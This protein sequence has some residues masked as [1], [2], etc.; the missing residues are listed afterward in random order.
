[1]RAAK[2]EKH[3]RAH[4]FRHSFATHVLEAGTDIRTLQELL[5]HKD[6][7]TTMLYTH[8]LQ[9][10]P[11]STR[12]PLETLPPLSTKATIGPPIEVDITKTKYTVQPQNPYRSLRVLAEKIR[13]K[14]RNAMAWSC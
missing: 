4:T 12:S 3:A 10:G 14:F 9:H 2:I 5:G 11:V 8:A 6:V 1:M 13:Q 7:R